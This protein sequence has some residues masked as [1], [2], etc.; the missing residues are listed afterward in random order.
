MG[1]FD[2][3]PREDVKTVALTVLTSINSSTNACLTA[4]YVSAQE[5][6]PSFQHST[7]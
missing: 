1:R 5:S 2:N 3:D 4:Q 7:C 6:M